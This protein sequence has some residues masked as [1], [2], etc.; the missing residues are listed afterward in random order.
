ME[1][2]LLYKDRKD[3]G[4]TLANFLSQYESENP[5][6]L[7]VPRGGVEVGLET[8]NRYHFDWDLIIP[9]KLGAPHNQEIAIGAV[10]MDGNY[11]LFEEY[12]HHIGVSDEYIQQQ[13]QQEVAEITRRS[14]TYRGTDTF[15]TVN[16]RT[17]ILIDDGIATGF[18]LLA[19][20]KSIQAHEPKKLILAV[21]VAPTETIEAFRQFVDEIICLHSIDRFTSVG[22]YYEY[23]NQVTDEQM[24]DYLEKLHCQSRIN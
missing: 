6:I 8:I 12:I 7:L 14:F 18:T 9:R 16:N 11:L 5:I 23:F 10:S 13:I 20:V 17:V 3:A 24:K 15:P 22:A 21:P 19:A 4:R 1:T 2:S